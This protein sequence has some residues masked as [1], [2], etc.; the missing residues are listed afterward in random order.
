MNR[1]V[2]SFLTSLLVIPNTYAA[3]EKEQKI[4]ME[5]QR[6]IELL[7]KEKEL[8]AIKGATMEVNKNLN[9]LKNMQISMKTKNISITNNSIIELDLH[10]IHFTKLYFPEGTTIF[11]SKPSTPFKD[12]TFFSNRVEI[13]PENDL[14]QASI[15]IS[16][17]YENKTYDMTIIANKYDVS[18]NRNKADNI[19][20]PKINFLIDKPLEAKEVIK[21]FKNDYGTLPEKEITK[22]KKKKKKKENE[23]DNFKKKDQNKK[24]KLFVL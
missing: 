1:I 21:A 20:Y 15:S 2:L 8:Q 3:T 19:F 4:N 23:K 22:K 13:R 10:P 17:I 24:A 9:D 16:F 18:S 14:L 5:N 12:N 11:S 7:E 6:I